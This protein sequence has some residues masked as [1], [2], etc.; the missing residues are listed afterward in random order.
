MVLSTFNFLPK[1]VHWYLSKQKKTHPKVWLKGSGCGHRFWH[2]RFQIKGPK[3]SARDPHNGNDS[4]STCFFAK[5]VWK[6]VKS[7]NAVGTEFC[8]PDLGFMIR[9]SYRTTF[10]W[11]FHQQVW[12]WQTPSKGPNSF[13][14][15]LFKS[16]KTLAPE[17]W[18]K[19]FDINP[20]ELLCYGASALAQSE[21]KMFRKHGAQS[22]DHKCWFNWYSRLFCYRC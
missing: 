20:T 22:V 2:R 8:F 4:S 13:I 17:S 15:S 18:G 11:S 5:V 12:Q 9:Y 19:G 7:R 6:E 21:K 16:R 3:P 10:Q 14:S 1:D